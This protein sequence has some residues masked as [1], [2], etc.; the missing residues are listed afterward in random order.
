MNESFN[1]ATVTK[2]D[3]PLIRQMYQSAFKPIYLKYQ[4]DQTD[5]FFESLVSLEEKWSRPNNHFYFFS[6]GNVR[7]GM[8]RIIV[9]QNRQIARLSPLLI[10]PQFQGRGF[11][12]QMLHNIEI[13]YPSVTTW[14]L[15]TIAEEKKLVHLYKKMGY[16]QDTT[17]IMAIKP[18]MTIIYF[19]KTI[20]R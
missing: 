5:P 11:A 7:V 20:S 19:S 18:G 8:L 15:D 1:F 4:D 14:H 12:Q 17:K 13:F 2:A 6:H 16:V 10:L 9:S 3:L